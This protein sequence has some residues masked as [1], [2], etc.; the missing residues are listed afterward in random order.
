MAKYLVILLAMGWAVPR[1]FGYPLVILQPN[2]DTPISSPYLKAYPGIEWR[3]QIVPHGGVPPFEYAIQGPA[4]MSVTDRGIVSWPEPGA[5]GSPHAVTAAITDA[6]GTGVSHAWQVTVTTAGFLF[7]DANEGSPSADGSYAHPVRNINDYYRSQKSDSTYANHIVYYYSG[8]YTLDG[9][10]I[11]SAGS[12]WE[13]VEFPGNKPGAHLAV[14]GER[15][16]FD[17]QDRGPMMRL[18]T[19]MNYLRGITFRNGAN[20][21]LQTG[22]DNTVIS[23]CRFENLNG[24]FESG[25]NAADIMFLA[26]RSPDG[27]DAVGIMNN[28]GV[29][30]GSDYRNACAIKMYSL[31]KVALGYNEWTGGAAGPTEG[32]AFKAGVQDY[33]AFQNRMAGFADHAFGGN[34]HDETGLITRGEICYSLVLGSHRGGPGVG[35]NQRGAMVL[36]Q[37][38]MAGATWIHHNTFQGRVYGWHDGPF[39]LENNVIVNEDYRVNDYGTTG[40]HIGWGADPV[41]M[42][43]GEGDKA[44]LVGNTASGIIDPNGLLTAAYSQ[45]AST[46]GFQNACPGMPACGPSDPNTP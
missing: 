35:D 34:M 20:M 45:Y 21:H 9:C 6:A 36:N 1:V 14:P 11:S 26:T 32:F 15:P 37:D 23:E 16:V 8:V 27:H 39:T 19:G 3:V 28:V 24:W 7:V 46:H 10:Q 42:V 18:G 40:V 41:Q 44:N 31:E 38:G 2:A 29:G 13:R 4:G 33:F 25:A 12:S 30:T 17:W 22:G 43:F 5:E